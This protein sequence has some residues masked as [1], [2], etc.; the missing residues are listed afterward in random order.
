MVAKALA[1]GN[2]LALGSKNWII[3]NDRCG[4]KHE[5]KLLKIT[6]CTEGLFTCADGRCVDISKRCNSNNDCNDWSDEMNCNLVVFPGS[7]FKNFAPFLIKNNEMTKAEVKVSIDILDII[8]VSENRASVMVKYILYMQWTD[9]RLTFRNLQ[10]DF[11]SNRLTFAQMD[12]LWF[13]ILTF[14]NTN[15]NEK[16][17]MDEETKMMV[18][19]K[20]KPSYSA[21]TDVDENSIYKGNDN[22]LLY[23]RTYTK[24]FRC[25]F[26]L[27]LY[28]F[29]TQYCQLEM[30][31]DKSFIDLFK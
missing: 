15:D 6:S 24:R 11:K 1:P 3:E 12:L 7:Y 10:E 19:K 4:A 31:I 8:E 17:I 22:N 23:N 16:V 29:D 25:D 26:K 2:S 20:G 18:I 30:S 5:Q 28:P 27:A 9:L 21:I 14:T 13:P